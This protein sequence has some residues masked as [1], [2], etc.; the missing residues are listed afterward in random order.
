VVVFGPAAERLAPLLD[1]ARTVVAAEI[2]DAIAVAGERLGGAETLLVS[3]MFPLSLEERGRV[4]P[5]LRRLL[6]ERE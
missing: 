4:A 1:R 5:A 2:D 3:P 6:E